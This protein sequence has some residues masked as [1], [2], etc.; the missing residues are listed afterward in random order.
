MSFKN[1]SIRRFF[2]NILATALGLGLFIGLF[3]W[4]FS[5]FVPSDEVKIADNSVLRLNLNRPILERTVDN[6]FNDLPISDQSSGIGL[7]EL[8]AAIRKAKNDSKIKGIYLEVSMIQAGFATIEDIR[9]ALI[10]F[11]TS[12]KFVY[13]Y[14]EFMTEGAYYLA[15]VA[16]KI[17]LNPA[18]GL[19]FNGLASTLTFFRGA[20]E[21]L[22]IKPEIFRVGEF[23]SAVE[24]FLL[25]KMSDANRKQYEELLNSVYGFYLANVA[26]SRQIELSELTRISKEYLA[27][28]PKDALKYRLVTHLAYYDEVEAEMKKNLKLK[29]K[30]DIEF[31]SFKTYDK[32]PDTEKLGNYDN[33]IAVIV[34]EGEIFSGKSSDNTIGS[35][36]IAAEIRKARQDKKVKA[37]VLRINSPGGS[38]LASDVMWREV[39]LAKKVKPVI[40]SMSDVAASGG[41]YMAMACDAIVA[42]PNTIT[43]SIGVFGVLFNTKD[44]F[45]NKLGI[46][47]D[48]VETGEYSNLAN[49]NF[50]MNEQERKMVQTAINQIYDDFTGKAAQGRKMPLDSLKKIAGGRVWSGISA[51][52]LGLVD[53]LGN[54]ED[55]VKLAAQKAKLKEGDYRLRYYPT[56]KTFYEKLM[57][58]F[59][60]QAKTEERLIQE[61]LGELYPYYRIMQQVKKTYY[62]QARLPY[63]IE[64]K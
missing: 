32:A 4:I 58:T 11:K 17:Y 25:D 27:Q 16:D 7:V 57:D 1:Y 38:A 62:V 40:A 24:P 12:K 30:D 39:M 48:Q 41:Y 10:D 22:E 61:K 64:I 9:N 23:K 3:F 56:Q 34:G 49:P 53:A 51:K 44:F 50:E 29:E 28:T 55:A 47:Y 5:W 42:Q 52:K 19:E 20:M 6:P 14:S 46:T 60:T 31:V 43:G 37:I 18:G 26:K 15:S 45:K 59:Q 21:K 35:E 13:A 2:S 8:K 63:D 36:T 33:R 54:L